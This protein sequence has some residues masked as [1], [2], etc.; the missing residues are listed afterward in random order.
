MLAAAESYTFWWKEYFSVAH[1]PTALECES[2]IFRYR[3]KH[4]VILRSHNP[5]DELL[6]ILQVTIACKISG[7]PVEFSTGSRF[8]VSAFTEQIVES[9]EEL[10][11]RLETLASTNESIVLRSI[12]SLPSPVLGAANAANISVHSAPTLAN[13]RIE[14]LH[15][16]SEQSVSETR[17]RY[18][19]V[20]VPKFS[21][22]GKVRLCVSPVCTTQAPGRK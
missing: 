1:D 8:N 17:H 16:L 14:L 4:R 20:A 22:S 13:G 12:T 15:Y 2:N 5:G 7:V 18:G 3:P 21:D 19:T 6:S 9:D 10:I 11:A